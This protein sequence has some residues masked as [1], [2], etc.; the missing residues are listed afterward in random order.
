MQS[1]AARTSHLSMTLTYELEIN[2]FHPLLVGNIC[3]KFDEVTLN[4]WSL[5]CS[6]AN[7]YLSTVILTLD[8]ENPKGTSSNYMLYVCQVLSR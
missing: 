5:S 1:P 6:Q 4:G 7:H 3:A 2:R 8:L